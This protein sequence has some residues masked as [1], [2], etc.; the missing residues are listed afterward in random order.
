MVAA[1][2]N[3]HSTCV[4]KWTGRKGLKVVALTYCGD[5]VNAADGVL[6]LP[7]TAEFCSNCAEVLE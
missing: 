2:P 3:G 6:Q 7:N 5:T 1:I 4:I